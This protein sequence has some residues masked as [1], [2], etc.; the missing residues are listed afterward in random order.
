MSNERFT[1]LQS[2]PVRLG[3]IL[4]AVIIV[5][6]I[7]GATVGRWQDL[8]EERSN[9]LITGPDGLPMTI[10]PLPQTEFYGYS[11][12]PILSLCV[13]NHLEGR[14]FED[15]VKDFF[16]SKKKLVEEIV[17]LCETE[18][19]KAIKEREEKKQQDDLLLAKEE[20]EKRANRV[21]LKDLPI[22][23]LSPFTV[24]WLP[25]PE[26]LD[27]ISLLEASSY[28]S[29]SYFKMGS[30]SRGDDLIY[31]NGE[32]GIMGT[33]ISRWV[34]TS[35]GKFVLLER[36]S[37]FIQGVESVFDSVAVAD[38]EIARDSKSTIPG[39]DAPNEFE[40]LGTKWMRQGGLFTPDNMPFN[41]E[42]KKPNHDL[43]QLSFGRLFSMEKKNETNDAIG[44]VSHFVR[45]ADGF[46]LNYK[47]DDSRADDGT[48]I[49]SWKSGHEK[50]KTLSFTGGVNN[51]GCGSVGDNRYY[52]KK[53]EVEKYEKVGD[54][55]QGGALYRMTGMDNAVFE[56]LYKDV[57]YSAKPETS[58]EEFAKHIT[59]LLSPDPLGRGY[60]FYS[61][62]DSTDFMLLA[63]CA[64]PVIYLYPEK[65]TEV[66]VQVG[67]HVTKSEP[68]YGSGWK[69]TAEPNGM[70]RDGN[71][72]K[73]QSL[74]WDG[75]GYGEYPM[76]RE[77]RVVSRSNIREALEGDLRALG[78]NEKERADFLEFWLPHMPN[79]PYVRLTWL[80]TSEM[81][82][83]APLA[84]SPRPE[85]VIRVFLDFAGQE[86]SET[87]LT[88]QT[89]S[90]IPR[91]GFTLV[92]WG[93]LLHS[94]REIR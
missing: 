30:T 88:P 76:I 59:I 83:L 25:V 34:K 24:N 16:V 18:Q 21:T 32:A 93:G 2:Q 72:K 14:S 66:S 63:E 41:S 53:D 58:R 11:V 40:Y 43:A 8:R 87:D 55:K 3:V 64:K 65:T 77:G 39:I 28:D 17:A 78:L 90:T 60:L 13:K 6:S 20:E 4:L 67:A 62:I 56:Y 80:T 69:V 91:M 54:L 45:I 94:S 79:T 74:F 82:R 51:G 52:P 35:D 73:W 29:I 81:N 1:F 36:Q 44:S 22:V 71:G 33:Y 15:K 46:Y 47:M 70:L 27:D 37:V 9:L 5:V 23:E 19:A 49:A 12:G 57:Q 92:E 86:F 89:L 68:E 48:L 50:F 85:T 75:T 7:A 61:S 26:K 42:T 38:G 84:V 10:H 31:S